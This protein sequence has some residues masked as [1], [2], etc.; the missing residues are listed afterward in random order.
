[1][2]T[3]YLA[4]DL[5]HNRQVA[6]K[7]LKPEIASALGAERFHREIQIAASLNHP[8]ILPLYDS[9]EIDVSLVGTTKGAGEGPLLFYVMPY[10]RGESLRARLER[11]TQLPVDEALRITRQVASAL[12]HAHARQLVHRDVKPENIL[13]HE[14]EAMV[15]DFGIARALST[16]DQNL[17][18]AGIVVGTAA[19]M[20]PE[21]AAGDPA[22]DA[23]SDVYALACVLY[24][25]LA[26]EPPFTGPTALAVMTKRLTDPVP[27]VRRLRP[28]VPAAVERAVT[29]ALA[30]VPADRYAST[31]SFAEALS[32]PDTDRVRA[33][34][35]AVLPFLNLSA[36]PEN[37][38]FADGI[39]EDVITHLSKVRAIEVISRTSVMPFKKREHGLREIAARL[40]VGT[41][42]DGSVRRAGARVRIVA[43]LIDAG[44][45]QHI[46]SET[47]DRELTDIFAIQTDVALHIAR[48]LRAELSADER[49]RIGREPTTNLPAYQLY[50]QGRHWLIRY[51]HEGLRKSIEYFRQAIEL[52][53]GYALAYTSIAIA[54]NE[55]AEGGAADPAES[56]AASRAALK[57]ALALDDELGEAHAALGYLHVVGGFRL[58]RRRTA[59]SGA[60]WN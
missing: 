13:I 19:Y 9:G 31:I 52:D 22:V 44:A 11:E 43:H 14:G 59:S 16:T 40:G 25:M 46:W 10:V 33:H 37:E 55:L 20:S 53:P 23:R 29:R 36:D 60:R 7:V 54:H 35:V 34:S 38:Y 39:T 58:E 5:K 57:A 47:Y 2:A 15:A 32:A 41:V 30:R 48:S 45:E 49:N 21:Q 1:M 6:L 4:H 27:S 18:G 51:T 17:T 24:E 8:H 12:D 3:V 56:Y 26:G 28:Q 42:L 50:L